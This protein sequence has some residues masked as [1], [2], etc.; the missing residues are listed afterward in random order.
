MTG[1]GKRSPFKTG[2]CLIEVATWTGLTGYMST[3]SVN[4]KF[5]CTYWETGQKSYLEVSCL[6][7]SKAPYEK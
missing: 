4:M 5:I 1:Q 7:V 6:S 2:D 3:L